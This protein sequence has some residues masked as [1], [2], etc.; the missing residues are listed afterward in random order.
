VAAVSGGRH[1]CQEDHG[2]VRK[3]M[4]SSATSSGR[5]WLLSAIA[6]S[7]GLASSRCILTTGSYGSIVGPTR[8]DGN[9]K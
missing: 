5:D 4:V 6:S 1:M 8:N 7:Y 3:F 2:C 9:R